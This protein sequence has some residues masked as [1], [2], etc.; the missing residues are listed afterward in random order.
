MALGSPQSQTE[1]YQ[2]Y[3]LVGKGGRCVGLTSLPPSCADCLEI[4][5]PQLLETSGPL[6]A[7][8]GIALP[9]TFMICYC[10]LPFSRFLEK[11]VLG[12]S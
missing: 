10:Y 4:L 8:N 7:S 9:F 3:L 2:E 5:E 1:E 11:F 12:V 6:R